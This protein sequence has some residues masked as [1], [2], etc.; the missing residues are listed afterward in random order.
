MC[1]D[2]P[3]DEFSGYFACTMF[4]LSEQCRLQLW[5]CYPKGYRNDSL[6]FQKNCNCWHHLLQHE[7]WFFLGNAQIKILNSVDVYMINIETLHM[8]CTNKLQLLV[9]S[10]ILE[11]SEISFCI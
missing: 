2:V 5:E 1:K 10:L 3:V 8:C 7:V 6:D 11:T 4:I 9:V